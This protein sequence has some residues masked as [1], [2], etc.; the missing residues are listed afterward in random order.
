MPT[1]QNKK[2]R[3]RDNCFFSLNKLL[4]LISFREEAGKRNLKRNEQVCLN[5]IIVTFSSDSVFRF[6]K[7][8]AAI[9][10]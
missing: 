3:S 10:K 5:V 1:K 8:L 6:R 9:N 2:L 7:L 4:A